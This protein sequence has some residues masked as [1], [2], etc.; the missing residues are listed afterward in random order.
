MPKI[1]AVD[2]IVNA[3]NTFRKNWGVLLGLMLLNAIVSNYIEQM[4]MTYYG[5][6]K[7]THLSIASLLP[8]TFVISFPLAGI[9]ILPTL[10]IAL[11]LVD[12][13]EFGFRDLF[14]FQ[15]RLLKYTVA[16]VLYLLV[17]LLGFICFIIPG[18]IF[19]LRFSLFPFFILEKK[20]GAIEALQASWDTTEN[21]AALMFETYMLLIVPALISIGFLLLLSIQFGLFQFSFAAVGFIWGSLS[22]LASAHIYRK[23]TEKPVAA[24]EIIPQEA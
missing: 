19:F 7:M 12:E 14:V 16:S 23:L 21:R 8:Q 6:M 24:A 13:G 22:L 3:W 18:I 17:T 11:K 2:M 5:L 20:M 4:Y 1:Y 9:F 15:E 10:H